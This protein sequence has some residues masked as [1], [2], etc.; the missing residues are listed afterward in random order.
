M[1]GKNPKLKKGQVL[2]EYILLMFVV[3]SAMLVFWR[4]FNAIR[5]GLWKKMACNI[6]PPCP[7]CKVT[8]D[9]EAQLNKFGGPCQ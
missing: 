8:P 5:E 3:L 2:V 6:V 4:G 7:A 1:A 9:T